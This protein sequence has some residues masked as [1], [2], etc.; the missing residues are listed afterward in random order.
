MMIAIKNFI[1]SY[2]L[3]YDY[4]RTV[5]KPLFLVIHTLIQIKSFA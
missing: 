1:D 2:L 3:G 4:A 5:N